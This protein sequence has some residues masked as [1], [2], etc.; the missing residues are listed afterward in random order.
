MILDVPTIEPISSLTSAFNESPFYSQ[1]RSRDDAQKKA[2][3]V[4]AVFHLCGNGV[5]EN[6]TYKAFM[7]GFSE[8]T[9]VR[10]S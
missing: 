5:L 6:E 4:H 9:Q 7:N 3:V 10:L 8:D 1:F 2:Y